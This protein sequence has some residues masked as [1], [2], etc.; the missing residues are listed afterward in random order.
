MIWL[1]NMSNYND[2]KLIGLKRYD[3]HFPF[4]TD[5]RWILNM[6][7]AIKDL[8][9]FK[10]KTVQLDTSIHLIIIH[11][12]IWYS[13]FEDEKYAWPQCNF[14]SKLIPPWVNYKHGKACKQDREQSHQTLSSLTVTLLHWSWGQ[15]LLMIWNHWLKQEKWRADYQDGCAFWLWQGFYLSKL[16]KLKRRYPSDFSL[17]TFFGKYLQFA[18]FWK[19]RITNI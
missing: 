11:Y 1:Q 8:I 4:M 17:Q 18:I 7:S 6:C 14:A 12:K 16:L 5:K 2:M 3:C 13:L 9:S 15:L 10:T 19:V